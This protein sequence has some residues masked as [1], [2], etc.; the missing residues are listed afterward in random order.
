MQFMN[1]YSLIIIILLLLFLSCSK[2]ETIQRAGEDNTPTELL[3]YGNDFYQ[4]GDYESAFIA[5][6]LIYNN[7]PTSQEYI[8]AM[9]GLSK[10]Y[11]AFEDFE[12]EFELLHNLLKENM[13]P[14]KVPQIYSA[15]AEFYE[16]S[17]GIS[18]Q[19]TGE[20]S[21]D[22]QTAIDYFQKAIYYPNSSDKNAKGYAQYRI[23][24]LYEKLKDYQH[25]IEAYQNTINNYPETQW[26]VKAEERIEEIRKRLERRTE[27]QPPAAPQLDTTKVTPPMEPDT[28]Q[29]LPGIAP[30]DTTVQLDSTQIDTTLKP[31]FIPDK[32]D[33]TEKPELELK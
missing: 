22:Y 26:V 8:D 30:P 12:K 27:F 15:I 1:K 14:S 17:A 32:L 31:Q 19:L 16:S 18:E 23:G 6:G 24:T 33:T 25:A 2:K 11:G 4:K 9:I 29:V 3:K 28:S 5:Y 20:S 10:C 13:I 7:Y 21:G